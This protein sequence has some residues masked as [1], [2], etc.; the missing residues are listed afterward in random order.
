MIISIAFMFRQFLHTHLNFTYHYC[1]TYATCKAQLFA[2]TF[3]FFYLI[4]VFIR[5]QKSK[6]VFLIFKIF[7]NGRSKQWIQSF[8]R[9]WHL[10][11]CRTYDHQIWQAGMSRLEAHLRLLSLV[12]VTLP[13]WNLMNLKTSYDHEYE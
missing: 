3:I 11:F 2:M 7:H 1:L 13:L 6:S 9:D 8:L 12:V 5:L 4:E 10:H